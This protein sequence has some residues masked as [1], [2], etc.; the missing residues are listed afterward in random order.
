MQKPWN[1]SHESAPLGHFID[2][3]N[4]SSEAL[5]R[6]LDA[7]NAEVDLAVVEKRFPTLDGA[8]RRLSPAFGCLQ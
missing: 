4:A 7:L 2:F 3:T 8:F 5:N 6:I 1:P